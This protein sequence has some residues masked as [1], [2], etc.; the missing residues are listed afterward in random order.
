MLEPQL[1]MSMDQLVQT[2]ML[3]ENLGFGYLFRSDH[4]LPTDDR[5][6]IDSPECWTSLGAIAASTSSIR[7]GPMV[8]PV[9]F[10]NPALLAKMASTLHSYSRGRLQLSVGAGWYEAE[11]RAHGYPF[12]AYSER[13]AQ[14]REALT[15]V[16]A[17]VRQGRADFDGKYFSA[18]T[19]C[20]P[21]PAGDLHL[22][23]GGKSKPVVRLAARQ[24]DEWN[25]LGSSNESYL[26]LRKV[27]DEASD[28][29]RVQISEMGPFMIGKNHA[30]LEESAG[31]QVSK[32]GS[33]ISAQDLLKRLRARNAPCGTPEEFVEHLRAKIDSGFQKFYFQTLVPENTSMIE[34]LADTLKRGI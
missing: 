16:V 22:I 2:A 5:R 30:E 9:G 7:F 21:R 18:H 23:I 1:G 24:A 8:T 14:F 34:L 32:F 28:S 15:I 29:R 11:F 31:L 17:L 10:R 13:L 4:L 6:G 26:G 3:A 12:P 27:F 19:D 33:G 20:L 25:L